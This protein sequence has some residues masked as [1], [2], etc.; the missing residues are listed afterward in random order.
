MPRRRGV[1]GTC[2][3]RAAR[4]L[5]EPGQVAAAR[6]VHCW[7]QRRTWRSRKPSGR[8]KSASPTAAGST[9]CR[10]AS[11]STMARATGRAARSAP[12]GVELAAGRGTTR[13]RRAP[14]RR[15]ARRSRRRPS[16]QREVRGTGTPVPCS[17]AMTR[18]SRPMSCAVASTWPERR[19]AHDPRGGAVGDRVGEVGPAAGDQPRRCRSPRDSPGAL[20]VVPGAKAAE[21]EPRGSVLPSLIRCRS[22]EFGLEAAHAG[23]PAV[24]VR[25]GA[26]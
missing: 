23:Q 22:V 8:P 5:V 4:Q 1:G 12:S 20:R 16:Q 6:G 11:T 9:A 3:R 26:A 19:A 14:S 21:V 24:G 15:T 7:P 2:C 10:S 25:A 13:R 18:Y 17:A